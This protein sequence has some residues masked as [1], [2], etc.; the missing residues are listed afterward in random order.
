MS[1]IEPAPTACTDAA[2]PPDSVLTTMSIAMLF[3]TAD[4]IAKTT[5]RMNDAMYIVLRPSRSLKLDHHSGK[6]AMLNMYT[7]TLIFATVCVASN[8]IDIS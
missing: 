6:T 5:K 7:A 1:A 3:D 4:K 2:A 8:A